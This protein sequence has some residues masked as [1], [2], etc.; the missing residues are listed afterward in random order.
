MGTH[1]CR[2]SVLMPAPRE[3]DERCAQSYQDR[4]FLEIMRVRRWRASFRKPDFLGLGF[5]NRLSLDA[6]GRPALLSATMLEKPF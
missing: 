4:N 1:N 2:S 6:K 5:S 3:K